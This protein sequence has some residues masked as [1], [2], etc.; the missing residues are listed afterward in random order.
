MPSEMP[1]VFSHGRGLASCAGLLLVCLFGGQSAGFSATTAT[2]KNNP[3]HK[4]A[5][6]AKSVFSVSARDSA[7]A[8]DTA[9]AASA[10]PAVLK[11]T[12]D[13][14]KKFSALPATSP[15]KVPAPPVEG[16]QKRKQR[17]KNWNSSLLVK[18]IALVLCAVLILAALRFV[19]REKAAVRFLTTTR[20][21][22]MDKEVQRA[23]RYIEKNFADPGLSL[24]RMCKDLVTGEAFLEALMERDLGVTVNDFIMHVRINQAKQIL[25]KAADADSEAVARETGFASGAAF[26]AAFR[27][28]TD[29][30]FD[31]YVQRRNLKNG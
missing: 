30:P 11:K 10:A 22:V 6:T 26:C 13:T 12:V 27:K 20:L 25:A 18:T 4:P 15:P 31:E 29:V 2:V 7:A 23:C 5:Q 16:G 19:T 8:K 1:R 17:L 14:L 9:S 28:I 24:E 21:S 3:A